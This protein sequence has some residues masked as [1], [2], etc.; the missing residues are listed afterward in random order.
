MKKWQFSV[1]NFWRYFEINEIE[2]DNFNT[3]EETFEIVY[4]LVAWVTLQLSGKLLVCGTMA[5]FKCYKQISELVK[6]HP[7][8]YNKQEKDFKKEEVKQRAWKEIAKELDQIINVEPKLTMPEAVN[9][10]CM[11][12]LCFHERIFSSKFGDNISLVGMS[13]R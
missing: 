6:I 5:P 12:S 2:G 1:A 3:F 8:L 7:C 10:V 11:P 9:D 4:F 13:W